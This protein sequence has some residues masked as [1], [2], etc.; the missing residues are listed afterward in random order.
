MW[1]S[2]RWQRFSPRA[3][4]I[5]ICSPVKSGTTWM[6]MICALLVFQRT[7][8]D[9]SLDL[10]SPWLEMQT[11]DIGDVI[12]D[13][14]AQEHRRFIKSHTPLDG[15][16]DDVRLTYICVG[17]D[18]R[19]VAISWARHQ[20]N[21]DLQALFT[22]R[23]RAVG[24]EDLAEMY[25][26]FE[27]LPTDP[28]ARFWRFVDDPSEGELWRVNFAS[29]MR[30]LA[31]AWERRDQPNVVLVHYADLRRD[32]E[33]EMR[34]IAQR[35]ELDI[36]DDRLSRLV[37]AAGFDS[38]RAR[39]DE[40]APNASEGILQSNQAFFHG[41]GNGQWRELIDDAG[42]RRYAE[43]VRQLAPTDLIEWV[44]HE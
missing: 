29:T 1:D 32:L 14:E 38:M 4:D 37:A 11:R 17:R 40:I 28:L 36:I 23:G 5:I 8:F 22:A 30:H 25:R 39:A 6:Q 10:I 31:T 26:D 43:R 13:L 34:R 44:H 35:L 41:G 33:G 2:D 42:R 18:P 20:D 16:P 27:P 24:N 15:L 3:G 19:D 12:A 9:R 21:L 7:T